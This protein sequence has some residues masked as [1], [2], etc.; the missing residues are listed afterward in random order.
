MCLHEFTYD[1]SRLLQVLADA[2]LSVPRELYVRADALTPHYVMARYPGRKPVVYDEAAGRRCIE[3][4]EEI[5]GRVVS[6]A[7]KA[8]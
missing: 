7:E 5:V 6:V 1:L 2:G 3:Y 4:M 8:S